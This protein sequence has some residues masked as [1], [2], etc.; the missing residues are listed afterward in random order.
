MAFAQKI[1]KL[2]PSRVFAH[3]AR[4][5]DFRFLS[6]EVYL[7]L[8]YRGETGRTLNLS[9][10]RRYTEKLQWMKV[11]DHNPLYTTMVDKVEAKKWAASIIGEEHIIPTLGVWEH[12]EEIDFDTLPEQFVLKCTHDSHSVLICKDKASFDYEG[13]RKHL[14]AALRREY[15]YEGRQWP[16]KNVKPR[17]IAETYM[18]NKTTGDLRDYKFFTFG[19][20]PKVMYIATGR[21]TGE[22]YGDFF[23][24]DF[25]HLELAIDHD[26]APVCPEKPACFEAMKQAAGLLARGTPQVRVDFY[27]VNGQFYFGEMTF[28]HCS[29]FVSFR[30]DSWD[31]TFGAWIPLNMDINK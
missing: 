24:M 8:L 28:F 23:N 22:T 27:E 1:K 16:Y 26:T 17:I 10:P 6:D 12:F 25:Q 31:E 14:E 21:G 11:Y 15:F 7:K 2:T 13:A 20:E 18:E 19:G 3:F 29:G 9:E 30:P 4:T 5:H